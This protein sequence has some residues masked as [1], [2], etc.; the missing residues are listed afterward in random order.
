MKEKQKKG[1]IRYIPNALTVGRLVLTVVFLGLIVYA[2]KTSQPKPAGLLMGAFV[3]FVITGLT[4]IIDGY[5]ARRFEVTSRFGRVVDP[6]AD[7]FLVCGAFFCFAWV[8]QPLMA[9]LGLSEWTLD[10]IRWGTAVVIFAREVVV[11]TLR[12]IAESRGVQF[13]AIWSGKLKMFLQSFGIGTVL[14]GWAYVSRPWGD[15]FTII[16]YVLM[17]LVTILSGIQSLTRRIK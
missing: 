8:N 1:L 5:L 10:F 11:Q 15:W 7:K 4:D 12:H 2:P 3:L 6:L 9:G 17:V 16:T 14:I 13:G